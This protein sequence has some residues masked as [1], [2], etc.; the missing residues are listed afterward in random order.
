MMV[1]V[2]ILQ[3]I[4]PILVS[5]FKDSLHKID[6]VALI[7]MAMVILIQMVVGLQGTELTFGLV[8]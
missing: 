3:E 2:T 6:L 1:M 5:V 8:T 4:T 7:L